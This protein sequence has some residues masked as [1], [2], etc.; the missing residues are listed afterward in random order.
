MWLCLSKPSTRVVLPWST[1][2]IIATLRRSALSVSF[3]FWGMDCTTCM[4]FIITPA[5][6]KK[7]GP[8]ISCPVD[9]N[10]RL[11]FL[12]SLYHTFREM[13]PNVSGNVTDTFLQTEPQQTRRWRAS[14][15][16]RQ[17][18]KNRAM[19]G[20]QAMASI[21]WLSLKKTKLTLASRL[22][23]LLLKDRLYYRLLR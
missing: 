5:K 8:V 17:V 22:L 23:C 9:W 20:S 12:R 13:Q 4:C 16:G 3:S 7:T 14:P 18:K 1:W 21:A 15:H 2:A 10:L 6:H 19:A 11:L